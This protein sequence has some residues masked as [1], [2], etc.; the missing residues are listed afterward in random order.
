M[1]RAAGKLVA[2]DGINAAAIKAGARAALAAAD[3]RSRGGVSAWD[4]SGIFQELAVADEEA[5]LPSARTLMLLYAADL[6]FRLRWEIRPA[7]ESGRVVVAAPYVHTAIAFGRAAGLPGGWLVDLFAF[8]PT[9][10]ELQI[11]DAAPARS[12]AQRDGFIE[13]GIE[14]VAALP[15]GLSRQQLLERA[16]AHLRTAARKK[17]A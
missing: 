1:T 13:Y 15:H 17:R 10:A 3:R 16:Q 6:S 2:V 7:V 12:A 4:A 14:R 11:V 5:G 8:A 9:P